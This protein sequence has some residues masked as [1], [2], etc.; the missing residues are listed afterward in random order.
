MTATIDHAQ[1]LRDV[2]DVGAS[3]APQSDTC[4]SLAV[5]HRLCISSYRSS[6]PLIEK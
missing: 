5:K 1:E 4:I 6:S 2:S 3:D